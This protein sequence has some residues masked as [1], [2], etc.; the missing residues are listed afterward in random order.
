MGGPIPETLTKRNGWTWWTKPRL[1][2]T[3]GKN[4]EKDEMK[5]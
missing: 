1:R 2:A 4:L 5:W 3:Q